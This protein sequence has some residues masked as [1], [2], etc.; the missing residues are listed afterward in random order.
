MG[1]FAS[2]RCRCLDDHAASI[3]PPPGGWASAKRDIAGFLL[4]PE[5]GER[6]R[7]FDAW[8]A[9]AC[10]HPMMMLAFEGWNGRNWTTLATWVREQCGEDA[11][12]HQLLECGELGGHTTVEDADHVLGI[13][14]RLEVQAVE[15]DICEQLQRLKHVC[16]AAVATGHA[17]NWLGF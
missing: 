7:E 13:L 14:C 9:S 3:A 11:A 5:D 15:P 2:V 17:I 16:D 8:A 10:P 1:N 12:L 4:P 6:L